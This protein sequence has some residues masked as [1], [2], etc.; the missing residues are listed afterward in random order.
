MNCDTFIG[1]DTSPNRAETI[2]GLGT[3]V[4]PVS[5]CSGRRLCC[6]C[7]LSHL[8]AFAGAGAG[9]ELGD[10]GCVA[11]LPHFLTCIVSLVINRVRGSLAMLQNVCESNSF[12]LGY[13]FCAG[14]SCQLVCN[15]AS[16][17][18]H[19]HVAAGSLC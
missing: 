10:R 16:R 14:S 11:H 7:C 6:M 13:V 19:W 17:L 1:K 15:I 18:F 12:L 5:A 8:A 9:A 2:H 4:H 3:A